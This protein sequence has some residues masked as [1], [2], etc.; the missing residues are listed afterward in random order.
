MLDLNSVYKTFFW[1]NITDDLSPLPHTLHK[2]H[3]AYRDRLVMFEAIGKSTSR[4]RKHGGPQ[5]EDLVSIRHNEYKRNRYSAIYTTFSITLLFPPA[6]PF[7]RRFLMQN[8]H[9]SVSALTVTT[10]FCELGN[11]LRALY[12]AQCEKI[13][14]R[15][16]QLRNALTI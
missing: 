11:K 15:P 16:L 13:R 10:T 5:I 1:K 6:R 14:P 8:I 12:T 7:A 3:T 4:Y 2:S 9:R